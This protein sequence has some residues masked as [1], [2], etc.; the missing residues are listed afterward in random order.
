M[1]EDAFGILVDVIQVILWIGT[2]IFF[3]KRK[4]WPRLQHT[5]VINSPKL[6]QFSG[7]SILSSVVI[8]ELRKKE[9][10]KLS[11]VWKV[12]FILALLY[13]LF[14]LSDI[15]I[16]SFLIFKSLNFQSISQLSNLLLSIAFGC[17]AWV[18]S[19]S[20]KAL[21]KLSGISSYS[22]DSNIAS[23]QP[24]YEFVVEA[25]KKHIAEQVKRALKSMGATVI[26]LD[27]VNSNKQLLAARKVMSKVGY[28]SDAAPYY[29]IKVQIS[30]KKKNQFSIRVESNA[31]DPSNDDQKGNISNV[32]EFMQKLLKG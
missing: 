2:L 14:S 21:F 22:S 28:V 27:V 17:W 11:K 1:D 24:L 31:D 12:Y 10:R 18:S 20:S 32:T 9:A 26:D 8:K 19:R 13:G 5:E 7:T 16:S 3:I 30:R 6:L 15:Y 4:L 23:K 29:E 25:D